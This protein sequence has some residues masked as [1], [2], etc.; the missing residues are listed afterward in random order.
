MIEL[1]NNASIDSL[2]NKYS[3]DFPEELASVN[4]FRAFLAEGDSLTRAQEIG[5][6][7]ASA[8]II[9]HNRDM[10]L[11]THHAKLDLWL[12]LGGHIEEGE[13]VFTAAIR[14]ASEESGLKSVRL[15]SSD[16]Y[17]IDAHLIPERKGLEE[18]FHFDLRF[19]IEADSDEA[20][21]I[22]SESKDLKWMIIEDIRTLNDG[23]SVMRMVK[24][25]PEVF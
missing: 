24:K 12:Q 5:H 14:E 20:L 1:Q 3:A 7:T 13:T 16:L 21:Q 15:L 11:L 2:L 22:S 6:F 19:L 17:D 8:W 23:P 10:A 25:C 9:N 4:L 18:H